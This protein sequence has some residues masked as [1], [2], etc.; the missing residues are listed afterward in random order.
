MQW[1]QSPE[2]GTIR[3]GG[4]F[5]EGCALGR[6]RLGFPAHLGCGRLLHSGKI[7]GQGEWASST[8]RLWG[9][10]GLWPGG[11]WGSHTGTGSP[12]VPWKG[13]SVARQW[14]PYPRR[15]PEVNDSPPLLPGAAIRM[16]TWKVRAAL[17]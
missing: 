14:Q 3:D 1:V 5:R 12:L 17:E 15:A 6:W 13:V 2:P 16:G 11:F 8:A 7:C 4:R 10:T 9:R